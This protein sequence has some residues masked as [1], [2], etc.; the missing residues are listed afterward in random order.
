MFMLSSFFILRNPLLIIEITI[1]FLKNRW[2]SMV[3][4][5]SWDLIR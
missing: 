5:K 1:E 2:I 3:L 4:L